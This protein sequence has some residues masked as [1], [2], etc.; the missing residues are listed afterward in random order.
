MQTARHAGA[1][2]V[3]HRPAPQRRRQARRCLLMLLT[4]STTAW[5]T[6]CGGDARVELSAA[7]SIESL[8]AELELGLR[9]YH[10][11]VASSDD[12]RDALAIA[13][14][15]RRMREAGD[16]PAEQDRHAG[17][18]AAALDRIRQDRRTE[19][20]RFAATQD[21]I[22]TLREITGGLRRLA[23]ESLTLRDEARR[24]IHALI[25][26]QRSARNAAD[27]GADHPSR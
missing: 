6:G 4:W 21:N 25:D 1:N 16:D 10:A 23:V 12:R 15:V 8:A 7:D 20:T 18:F 13:A 27:K 22:D 5:V 9:E 19:W 3:G 17:E 11:D 2:V 14:F 24:Y 26:V